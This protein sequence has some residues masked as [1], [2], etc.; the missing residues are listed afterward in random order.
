MRKQFFYV[1]LMLCIVQSSNAQVTMAIQSA[2]Q[3]IVQKPQLWNMVLVYT[4][5]TP[6]EIYIKLTLLGARD[7]RPMMSA[8]SRSVTI[9]KGARQINPTE[10]SPIQYNYTSAIFNVDPGADG[11]LPIGNYKACYTIYKHDNDLVVPLAEDCIP[12]EV[13]PLSPPILSSPVDATVID[14]PFPQFTWLPAVPINLFSNLNY[15][16]ILVE[17]LKGQGKLDAVQKNLPV[18]TVNSS[19]NPFNNYPASS[20]TLDTGRSYAWK[21]VAKN[22]MDP[23]AQSEVWTFRIKSATPVLSPGQRG[24]YMLMDDQLHAVYGLQKDTLQIKYVSNE[25]SRN[26]TIAF[27][28]EKGQEIQHSSVKIMQ[29]DN[30]LDFPLNSQFKKEVT[31]IITVTSGDGKKHHLQFRI[32]NKQ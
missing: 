14:N 25:P 32:P 21:V 8:S 15:D 18:Y 4:G 3:G 11:F 16:L 22:G 2:P 29:G 13:Q 7:N 26:A 27:T 9:S 5:D 31:Y 17:V 30:Y 12:I 10:L 23:V 28:D 1:L 6:M 24:Y 20:K 19:V